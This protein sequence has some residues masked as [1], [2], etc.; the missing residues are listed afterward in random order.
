VSLLEMAAADMKKMKTLL[1]ASRNLLRIKLLR[2]AGFD[3]P[4]TGWF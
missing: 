1:L 4:P 2:V 3:S